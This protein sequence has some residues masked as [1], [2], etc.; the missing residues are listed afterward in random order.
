MRSLVGEALF[1]R[2]Q[3]ECAAEDGD[4]KEMDAAILALVKEAVGATPRPYAYRSGGVAWI[5]M[6]ALTVGELTFR[7]PPR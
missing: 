5:R 2:Q 6:A 4:W 1:V 3:K 7:K